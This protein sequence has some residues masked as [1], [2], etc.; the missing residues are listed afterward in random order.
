MSRNTDRVAE[1]VAE[2]V[3]ATDGRIIGKRL[4]P[5]ARAAGYA[6]SAR[7]FRRAVADAKAK[8]RRQRPIAICVSSERCRHDSS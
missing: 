5:I 2:K 8:W 6:G 3:K 7:N 4:L 1:V